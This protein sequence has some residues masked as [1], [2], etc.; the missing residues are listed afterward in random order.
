MVE[1]GELGYVVLSTLFFT[2]SAYAQLNDPDPAI[3]VTLYLVGGCG[4]NYLSLLTQWAS[5]DHTSDSA[6]VSGISGADAGTS[7]SQSTKQTRGPGAVLERSSATA[8][9]NGSVLFGTVLTAMMWNTWHTLSSKVEGQDLGSLGM[10]LGG[11]K[12]RSVLE[13]LVVW[14]SEEVVGNGWTCAV[15]CTR[16]RALSLSRMCVCVCVPSS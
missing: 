8:G 15:L 2:A 11:W 16:A 12:V 10:A 14:L 13:D 9:R 6:R 4:L 3:W 1:L 5:D 7:S